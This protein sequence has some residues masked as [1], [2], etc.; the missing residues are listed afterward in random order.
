[1]VCIFYHISSSRKAFLLFDFIGLELICS[2]F[3][4]VLHILLLNLEVCDLFTILFF[5]YSPFFI[6]LFN[7]F[8]F[9]S[10]VKLELFFY[11][12]CTYC[13]IF[14]Y[15]STCLFYFLLS[16]SFFGLVLLLYL[17]YIFVILPIKN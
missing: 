15:V 2:H 9:I 13:L 16:Y 11:Y 10:F 3:S 5:A 4:N 1:M 14:Y 8:F 12:V 7:I 17:I 6:F